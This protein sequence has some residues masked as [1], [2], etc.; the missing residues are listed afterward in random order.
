[1]IWTLDF[2]QTTAVGAMALF[3]GV[4]V[5]RRAPV[6]TVEP[7]LPSKYQLSL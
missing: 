7:A 1:M 4:S 5:L 6:F 2:I 3:L